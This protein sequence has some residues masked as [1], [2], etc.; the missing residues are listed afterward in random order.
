MQSRAIESQKFRLPAYNVHVPVVDSTSVVLENF[1][2]KN[3]AY[4]VRTI[5]V[6]VRATSDLRTQSIV[7]VLE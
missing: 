5:R 2:Q 7:Y 4:S 6:H 1:E 3:V